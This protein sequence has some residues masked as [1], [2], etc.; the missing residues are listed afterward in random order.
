ML[1]FGRMFSSV[2]IEINIATA[3][4]VHNQKKYHLTENRMI[5][6][7]MKFPFIDTMDKNR[8]VFA[9]IKFWWNF[10]I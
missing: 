8:I 7:E 2:E 1:E 4:D 9:L 6:N 3:Q 10:P 5:R